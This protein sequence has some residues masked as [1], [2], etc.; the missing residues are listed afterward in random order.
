M[1]ADIHKTQNL[2]SIGLLNPP[3]LEASR[4]MTVFDNHESIRI[5]MQSAALFTDAK[6]NVE[7]HG[8]IISSDQRKIDACAVEFYETRVELGAA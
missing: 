8:V 3:P 1:L 4:G 2:E 6:G 5:D 7:A